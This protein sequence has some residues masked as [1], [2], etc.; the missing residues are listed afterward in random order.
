[1]CVAE[2][3]VGLA[4]ERGT[5]SKH[6]TEAKE[7]KDGRG[8]DKVRYVFCRNV[9][10]VLAAVIIIGARL[11]RYDHKFELPAGS[12]LPLATLGVLL[13]WLG[14][15]GF[16]G[17][18]TLALTDQFP[19]IILNT[20]LSAIW[21]CICVAALSYSF[22]KFV[23]ISALLNGLIAGLVG[24]TAACHVVTPSEA[25]VIG[26]VSGM[27]VHFGSGLMNRLEIDDALMVVPAHLMAGIWGTLAVAIFGDLEAIGTGLSRTEQFFVQILGIVSI[28][29]YAFFVSYLF[30]WIASHLMLLRVSRADEKRGL[31]VTEHQAT[32]ETIDL[33]NAMEEQH[34]AGDYSRP[35]PEEPFTEVGQIAH[36][37]NQVISRVNVEINERDSAIGRYQAS[38]E[39]KSAIL[40]SSMDCILSIDTEGRIIEFNPAAERTFGCLKK[41]IQGKSFV[42]HFVKEDDQHNVESSLKYKF[43]TSHGLVLNRRNGLT[44]MRNSG[45]PFPAEITITA[46]RL[47]SEHQSEFTLH[48]RDITRDLKIQ[49]RLQFLAYKDSLTGLSNRAH[50][51]DQLTRMER[52]AKQEETNIGLLFLDL[53]RFKQIND[54][55]GHK[56]GDE[57]LIEVGKRLSTIA[58][59]N[60][61]I[62]R[63]GGDEFVVL[64]CGDLTETVI[65]QRAEAIL[66]SMRMSFLIEGKP[67]NI[68][69]SIGAAISVHGEVEGEKLLQSAD[70][71]MYNA[72]ESGRD[73]VKFFCA[74][75]AELATRSATLELKMQEAVKTDAFYLVYQPKVQTDSSNIV[76][77]EALLRWNDEEH[78]SISPNEFIPIAEESN[79]I[80]EIDQRVLREVIEQIS[81]WKAEGLKV[82]PVSVNISGVHLVSESIVDFIKDALTTFD[83]PGELLEIE[84]TEGVLLRD[85][86][87]CIEVMRELKE[88]DVQIS[89]DDFGTGYSSLNYLKKLP[90][91]MLKIDQTFIEECHTK[92]EDGQ[93]CA[94]ILNLARSLNL[95]TIAEGVETQE[96]MAFLQSIGCDVFQGFYF[97]KPVI[98]SEISKQLSQKI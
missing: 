53:D 67:Y 68:P 77:M 73:N 31:N 3:E 32:T 20:F 55:L 43:T 91:D 69:T 88:L 70:I 30:I 59:D 16:N 13:I 25:V 23:D 36:K 54:T 62:A 15:I 66:T 57:L 34:S 85:I 78:G 40:D 8:N 61:V 44:L 37:Y 94:T 38:E 86:D 49:S 83:V 17:G 92:D 56:A 51:L 11:G 95:N 71:A 4:N 89:I 98:A 97:Y 79:L 64:M 46:A 80:I 14:W 19:M 84:I 22:K 1:M 27:V 72:K 48:I 6:E 42:T 9:D 28:G 65:L 24:I 81:L 7:P 82:V 21:S 10:T 74:A 52:K 96:Q 33:L 47:G 2:E 5:A 90:L 76:S 39:R 87:R 45:H 26:L 29:A 12:N 60:D 58:R 18:S 50:L 63:W 75:M 41:H 35:V 93:I